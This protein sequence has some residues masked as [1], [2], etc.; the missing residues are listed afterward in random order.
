MATQLSVHEFVVEYS[1][2][3]E[4]RL[5]LAV[6]PVEDKESALGLLSRPQEK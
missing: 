6:E 3:A 2:K 5:S 4:Q 1:Q